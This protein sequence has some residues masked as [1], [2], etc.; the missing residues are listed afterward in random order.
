VPANVFAEPRD[1]L[2]RAR[3][4]L[5]EPL[6]AG[7]VAKVAALLLHRQPLQSHMMYL[8]TCRRPISMMM[9]TTRMKIKVPQKL[10]PQPPSVAE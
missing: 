2:A 8:P 9:T 7:V 10:S 6:A 1:L 3:A 5:A 4:R